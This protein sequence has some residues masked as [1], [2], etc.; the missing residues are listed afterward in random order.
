MPDFVEQA[1]FAAESAARHSYG[2][3]VAFLGARTHDIAAAE[4]ALSEAFAAVL[5]EWP[6][7]GCL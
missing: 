5:A 1:R 7:K 6:R 2:K 4:D 3:L